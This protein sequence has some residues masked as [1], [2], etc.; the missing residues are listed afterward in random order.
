MTRPRR[1]PPMPSAI[2]S[3]SEPLEIALT[4]TAFSSGELHDPNPCRRPARSG[5]IRRLESLLFIH[6]GSF[7]EAQRDVC[8][9]FSP[10]S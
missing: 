9:P 10:H 5:D 4:S 6:L 3:P 8:N 2:S 1:D 7:D